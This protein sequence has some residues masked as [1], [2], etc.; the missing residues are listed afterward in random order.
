MS[1]HNYSS[2]S[3]SLNSVFNDVVDSIYTL[4]T[5]D[6]KVNTANKYLYS[7]YPTIR[8]NYWH[9]IE[10]FTYP[11]IITP[12]YPVSD[13][14]VDENLTSTISI[15]VTGFSDDEISVRREDLKLI[16]EGKKSEKKDE[17]EKRKYFYKNIAERDFKVEYQGSDK[18]DFEKLEAKMS[19]GILTVIIP[20]KEECKPV[21]QSYTIKK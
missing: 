4:T 1:K 2:N 6:Y 7:D 11:S 21:K 5:T 9:L 16:V 3:I 12:T 14:Y 8:D 10:S 15:A 13:Y 19:K 18:W 17:K 20:V